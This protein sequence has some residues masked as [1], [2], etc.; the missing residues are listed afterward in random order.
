M[1][2]D[3]PDLGSDQPVALGHL[4]DTF[5]FIRLDDGEHA[6][7]RLRDHYLV[8]FHP[9]LSQGDLLGVYLDADAALGSHLG[10]RGRN[11]GGAEVLEGDKEVFFEQLETT[12]DEHLLRERVPD[13]DVGPPGL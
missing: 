13:L 2:G 6:F 1:A 5:R 7:L 3:A 4:E 8:G 11:A 12:L 10:G 9:A